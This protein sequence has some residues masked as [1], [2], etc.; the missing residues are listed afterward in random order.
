MSVLVKKLSTASRVLQTKGVGGIRSVLS[1]KR[2]ALYARLNARI[3]RSLWV[4]ED[5]W[6]VGKIV[7]LRGNHVQ[8]GGCQFSLDSPAIRTA[9][10]SRLFFDFVYE[11]PER[12]ALERYLKPE[13]PV[14]ELGASIGVIACLTN[15]KLTDPQRHLVVEANPDLLR[16]LVENRERNAC[17]FSVM[18]AAIGY[19]AQET[20]FY[21][22]KDFLCGSLQ[23]ASHKYVSVKTLGL[24]D[25][26][27]GFNYPRCTLICDI[28]GGE[29]DLIEQELG[30]IAERV[31]TLI[32]EIHEQ[33]LGKEA[34]EKVIRQLEDA[35]LILAHK[36]WET[37]V[38]ENSNALRHAP[39]TGRA[40]EL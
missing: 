40:N 28:E 7:E 11:T 1:D 36:K 4:W 29:G 23:H 25:V 37:Y 32:I 33:V 10:K 13:L 9:H 31:E 17:R 15:K 22:H 12:D 19:G 18:H 14:V 27:N 2:Q 21:Q 5:H 20:M 38:F 35:G 16:L 34:V 6:W 39:A 30:L 3:A 24:G 8:V 26:L